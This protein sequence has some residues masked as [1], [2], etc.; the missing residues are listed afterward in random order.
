MSVYGV[1]RCGTG[2]EARARPGEYAQKRARYGKTFILRPHRPAPLLPTRQPLAAS[3]PPTTPAPEITVA[4]N[5]MLQHLDR[6][7][8]GVRLP[9]QAVV[10]IAD[11]FV[12]RRLEA[13]GQSEP[14]LYGR[15]D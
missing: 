1:R 12:Q 4:I 7:F 10:Q 8:L 5:E 14:Q 6:D 3:F 11:V 13:A 2:K 15:N 9:M